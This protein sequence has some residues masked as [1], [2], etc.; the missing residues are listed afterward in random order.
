M[1]AKSSYVNSLDAE[2]KRR[3]CE[4]L[5]SVGL[6]TTDDPYLPANVGKYANDMTT[7]PKIEFSAISSP[8]QACTHK[9]SSFRGSRWMRLI[10]SRLGM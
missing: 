6:S 5:S 9:N 2:A 8:G 10:I 7:W 3:Y 4:K 1:A